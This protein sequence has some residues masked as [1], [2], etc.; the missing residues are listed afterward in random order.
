[1]KED[2]ISSKSKLSGT[3]CIVEDLNRP[4]LSGCAAVWANL[5]HSRWA[6]LVG[7]LRFQESYKFIF[8]VIVIAHLSAVPL[9]RKWFSPRSAPAT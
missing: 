5:A 7:V 1:M 3:W 6:A 8:P 2:F 4:S 9:A